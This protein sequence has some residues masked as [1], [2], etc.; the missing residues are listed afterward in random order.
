M[1]GRLHQKYNVMLN[2]LQM[3][4]VRRSLKAKTEIERQ[5]NKRRQRSLKSK[6]LGMHYYCC[7]FY[8]HS[9]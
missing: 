6:D 2:V 9:W 5:N 8:K 3:D 7:K 1:V 4:D